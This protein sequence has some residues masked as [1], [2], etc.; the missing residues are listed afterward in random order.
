MTTIDTGTPTPPK[1]QK[2]ANQQARIDRTALIGVFGRPDAPRA[3][4]R[5]PRGETHTVA[6]GDTINGN[7]IE[8]IGMDLVIVSRMGTQSILRMPAG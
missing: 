8:A 1:V 7:T 3:L 5:L 6:I 4:I 2:Y